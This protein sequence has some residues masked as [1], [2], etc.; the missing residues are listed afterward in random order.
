MNS[1]TLLSRPTV[2]KTTLMREIE[3]IYG[4][5]DIRDILIDE[6]RSARTDASAIVTIEGRLGRFLD[7]SII[8]QWVRR[9]GILDE[10]KQ[11]RTERA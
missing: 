6:I 4:D 3:G 8:S 9:L 5:E 11:A 7:P 1:A 10:A 2:E